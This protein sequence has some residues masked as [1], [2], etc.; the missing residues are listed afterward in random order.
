M[1]V[2]KKLWW[3]FKREKRSYIVGILMLVLVALLE[4]VPPQIIGRFIDRIT[5][6]TL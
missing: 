2:F 4:L 6:N 3:F 5:A 1:A